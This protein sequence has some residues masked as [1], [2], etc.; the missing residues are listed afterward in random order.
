LTDKIL[1][2]G[3]EK[4]GKFK[5]L[6]SESVSV[7]MD[8]EITELLIGNSG[9]TRLLGKIDVAENSFEAMVLI[10]QSGQ[11]LVQL[12]TDISVGMLDII[13]PGR[14]RDE[15]RVCIAGRVLGPLDGFLFC[16]SLVKI[17]SHDLFVLFPKDV[18]AAF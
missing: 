12:I 13:P 11:G 5:I 4:V 9:F 7:E 6:I 8:D 1:V 15:K 18:G 10:L 17:V 2:G 14:V 3:A 16:P